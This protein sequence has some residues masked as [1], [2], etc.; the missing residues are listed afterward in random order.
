L[1]QRGLLG[2]P[3]SRW[4]VT[5]A[6]QKHRTIVAFGD[7][8]IDGAKLGLALHAPVVDRTQAGDTTGKAAQR[9]E[10]IAQDAPTHVVVSLGLADLDVRSSL[11]ATVTNLE[12]VFL[13]LQATGA[14]VAYQAPRVPAD[15]GDNWL[16]AIEDVCRRNGVAWLPPG[17]PEQT[18]AALG[19]FF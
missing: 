12:H 19:A 10:A 11:E 14:M 7:E 8:H 9:V 16:M 3:A 1:S 4:P 15:V 17:A 5:N 2:G 18:A 6:E 13:R